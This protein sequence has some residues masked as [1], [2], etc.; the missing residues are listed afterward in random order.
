[1]SRKS[2]R[3]LNIPLTALL[4]GISAC[5]G[6]TSSTSLPATGFPKGP[7]TITFW[8][9]SEKPMND[10]FTNSIIP[11][12]ERMHPN[13]K[14]DY[15]VYNTSDVI[16]KVLTAVATHTAPAVID[17]PGTLLAVLYQKNVL[18]PA[19]DAYF[20]NLGVQGL[21]NEYFAGTLDAQQHQGHLYGLPYQENAWSLY[22]NI[23][24]WKAAGLDPVKDAPKTWDD[25]A[26]L[27]PLLTKRD[28]SGRIVQ[29]GFSA[30]MTAGDHFIEW[31]FENMMDEVGGRMFDG[32]GRPVWN[33]SHGIRVMQIWKQAQA[34]AP[35]VTHND[36][37]DPYQDFFIGQDAMAFGG[38]NAGAVGELV[39]PAMKGNWAAVPLPQVD[40]AHPMTMQYS[41]DFV[42]SKDATPDQQFVAWNFIQY[43]LSTPVAWFKATRLLQPL[44]ALSQSAEAQQIPGMPVFLHDLS[45]ARPLATSLHVA[46]LQSAIA[47]AVQ[48]IVLDGADVKTSLDQSVQDYK[49]AAG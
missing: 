7:V 45:I 2:I 47:R 25:V 13:V 49:Q 4:L 38:P 44:K 34:V 21:V 3:L 36:P 20:P 9:D 32:S 5:S 23:S 1:M 6:N 37:S 39:N 12:Y 30:R 46:E 16:T 43:A 22:E 26:R 8:N 17:V 11:G 28:G 33:D 31:W 27:N 10:L 40:P 18:A 29:K 48:R 15:Q 41:F 24:E 19:A 42:V 35:T 14:V